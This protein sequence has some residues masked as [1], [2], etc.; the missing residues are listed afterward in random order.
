MN[1]ILESGGLTPL[2]RIELVWHPHWAFSMTF[3][4][5]ID[6]VLVNFVCVSMINSKCKTNNRVTLLSVHQQT[7]SI[8]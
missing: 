4:V 1:I 7:V 5:F 8:Y 3:T 6:N 2:D